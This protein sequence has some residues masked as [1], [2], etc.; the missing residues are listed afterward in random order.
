MDYPESVVELIDAVKALGFRG[1]AMSGDAIW[2]GEVPTPN[3]SVHAHLEIKWRHSGREVHLLFDG[4][5]GWTTAGEWAALLDDVPFEQRTL[6]EAAVFFRE[7]ITEMAHAYL[8]DP[9]VPYKLLRI[10]DGHA[11][12]LS[13]RPAVGYTAPAPAPRVVEQTAKDRTSTGVTPLPPELYD[14]VGFLVGLGFRVAND[15]SGGMGGRLLRLD[16][17]VA[18]GKSVVPAQVEINGDRGQWTMAVRFRGTHYVTPDMWM[19]AFGDTA[20]E[21]PAGVRER[22]AHEARYLRDR[23]TD[24]AARIEDDPAAVK[25]TLDRL[26]DDYRRK[27]YG[28]DT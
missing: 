27:F 22:L 16:G 4:M 19:N 21:R 25:E 6:D 7:R 2:R 18:T 12:T 24:I 8:L 14:L 11:A 1:R 28:G 17:E 26:E 5:S 23:L 10:R 20:S 15:R 9:G 3:G 13:V